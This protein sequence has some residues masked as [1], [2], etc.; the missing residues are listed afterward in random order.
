MLAALSGFAPHAGS[1]D[2]SLRALAAAD[3]QTPAQVWEYLNAAKASGDA[4]VYASIP[5]VALLFLTRGPLPF[6]ATWKLFLEGLDFREQGVLAK[7]DCIPKHGMSFGTGCHSP[8]W[9]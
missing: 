8:C 4:A 3:P 9:P 7:R 6:E 5:K 1:L 2:S